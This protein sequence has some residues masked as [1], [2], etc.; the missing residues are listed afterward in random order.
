MKFASLKEWKAYTDSQRNMEAAVANKRDVEAAQRLRRASSLP[1]P[2]Q[3]PRIARV[4]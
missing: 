4:A 2:A 3:G 1:K